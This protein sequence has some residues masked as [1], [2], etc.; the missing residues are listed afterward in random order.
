MTAEDPEVAPLIRR[1]VLEKKTMT[2]TFSMEALSMADVVVVDVQCDFIKEDLGNVKSGNADIQ[3]LED[4][5]KI[6]GQKISPQTLVLIETTVPPG[7]TEYIAYPFIKKAFEERGI[8]EEPLLAHSFERV[9]PGKE[10]CSLDPE[11]LAGLQRHQRRGPGP[12]SPFSLRGH[13]SGE[14]SLDGLGP[15]HGE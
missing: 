2:A 13:R 14:I 4:S 9:M 6:I 3:A 1:C 15:S 7:T 12:G 10:L 8:S 5:F 11:F